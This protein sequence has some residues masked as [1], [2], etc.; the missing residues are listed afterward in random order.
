M[1]G[2]EFA[3]NEII[4]LNDSDFFEKEVFQVKPDFFSNAAA[5]HHFHSNGN[6]TAFDFLR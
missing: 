4:V 1:Y 3:V 6:I 2:A 5:T